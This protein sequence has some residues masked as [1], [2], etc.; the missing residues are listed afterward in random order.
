MGKVSGIGPWITKLCGEY[1]A[2]RV[3][4]AI[5]LVP[6]R[7]DTDWFEPLW[8]FP[9]CFVHGRLTFGNAETSAPFPSVVAYLGDDP[10]MF[11]SYFGDL[12]PIVTRFAL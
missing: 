10:A 8:D 12:G 4:L 1:A 6:A 5:A 2:N 11:A 3:C 7:T 9:L